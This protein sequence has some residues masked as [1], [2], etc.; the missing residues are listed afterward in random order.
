MHA[1]GRLNE[2]EALLVQLGIGEYSEQVAGGIAMSP[3]EM[4]RPSD[5]GL[6]AGAVSPRLAVIVEGF[7]SGGVDRRARLVELMRAHHD[8]T[9]G[10]CGL[11]ETL[12]TIREEMRKF[13][14]S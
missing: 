14:E 7:S 3:G 10:D 4:V 8:A 12:N 2:M 11:E 1:S 5:L 13:A 6:S 9:F